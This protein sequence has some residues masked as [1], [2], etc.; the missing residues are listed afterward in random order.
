MAY[1][2]QGRDINLDV[3]RVQGYRHFCNKLWNATKFAMINGLG[4]K[5]VP[6]KETNLSNNELSKYLTNMDKWILNRLNETVTQCDYAFKNFEFPTATTACYNFWLYDLCDFYIEYL[7]PNFYSTN[8]DENKQKCSRE[9]LYTCLDVALRLI[10]PFMPFI[11][12]E[13]YQRLPRRSPDTDAP[14]ITVTQ[15]P[16]P[17]HFKQFKN[18]AIEAQFQTA[19]DAILKIRSLRADYQLTNKVK[20]ECKFMFKKF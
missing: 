11:S 13:L 17:E 10:S 8:V 3:L 5:F 7:K 4:D 1:T 6:L 19:K 16:L 15:Y 2:S 12:E 9:V 18:D 14:S 20:T